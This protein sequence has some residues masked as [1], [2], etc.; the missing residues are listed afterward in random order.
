LLSGWLETDGLTLTK[1]HIKLDRMGVKV[2][3]S[4]LYR[5]ARETLGF[6]SPKV[7]VR[8]ADTEPGEVAQVDFGRM[9][10]V[11][12]YGGSIP[13]LALLPPPNAAKKE[14]KWP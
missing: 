8:M 5:Y 3:Y 11:G 1:A 13:A 4:S 10:L 12:R 6:G 14:R 7:T 2:S 9:G